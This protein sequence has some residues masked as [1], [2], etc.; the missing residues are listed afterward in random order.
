MFGEN[1]LMRW[2]MSADG[3]FDQ[4][5]NSPPHHENMMNPEFTEIGVAF[6]QSEDGA[7]FYTM[8]LGRP[9]NR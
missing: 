9:L 4:W 2:D 1:V 6:T 5:W 3:A 8:V 7:Y